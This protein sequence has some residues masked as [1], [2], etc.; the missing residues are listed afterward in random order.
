M[1]VFIVVEAHR[2]ADGLI[3][4]PNE[5]DDAV[6]DAGT[7]KLLDGAGVVTH[8]DAPALQQLGISNPQGVRGPSVQNAPPDRHLVCL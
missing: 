4:E 3:L 8:Q 6:I 7:V 5:L 1:T 2:K